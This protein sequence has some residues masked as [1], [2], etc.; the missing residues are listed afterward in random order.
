[1]K[2]MKQALI[3]LGL[4]ALAAC[5]HNSEKSETTDNGVTEGTVVDETET[6]SA[7]TD[8]E[9]SAVLAAAN[10]AEIEMAQLAQQKATDPQVKAFADKM[11]AD[12]RANKKEGADVAKSSDIDVQK[13]NLSKQVASDTEAKMKDLKVRAGS[14]FDQAYISSQITMHEELL[15]RLNDKYIPGAQDTQFRSYL[16]ETRDHVQQHLDTAQALQA[17]LN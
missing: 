7:T 16:E 6:V 8:G 12:H 1:M 9:V 10:T 17:S 5:A 13:S 2:L 14:D 3:A 11:V 4:A 15:A